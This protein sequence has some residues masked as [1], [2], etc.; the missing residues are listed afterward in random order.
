MISDE[1]WNVGIKSRLSDVVSYDLLKL[2]R[3]ILAG[4]L[5]LNAN[6]HGDTS[7]SSHVSL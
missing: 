5:A 3:R 2:P 1:G 7:I 6:E 4:W